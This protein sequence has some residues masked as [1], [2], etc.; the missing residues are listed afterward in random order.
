MCII[1]TMESKT[2]KA[3]EFD[4]VLEKLS[5]YAKSKQSKAICLNLKPFNEPE[6]IKRQLQFTHEAK[7]IYDLAVDLPLDY[8]ADNFKEFI[9]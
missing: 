4:K 1:K 9:Y 6:A 7:R 3:L 8:N 5:N 2:L